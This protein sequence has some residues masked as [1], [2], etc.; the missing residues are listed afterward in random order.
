MQYHENW[1]M[2]ARPLVLSGVF[3]ALLLLLGPPQAAAEPPVEVMILGSYHMANPGQDVHNADVDDVTTDA[4][5]A[6]L[7][8]VSKSLQAFAP[9]KVAIERVSGRD[10]LTVEAYEEFET[11]DLKKTRNES[12][13]IGFRLAHDLGHQAVYGIDEQSDSIDYFPFGKVQEFAKASGDEK[14]LEEFN[15]QAAAFVE[16]INHAQASNPVARALMWV[17]QPS[18][19]ERMQE[20]WYYG[21]LEIGN[22]NE[23]PGALVNGRYYLRNAKIF[24]KLAAVTEPGDRVVVVFGS[25]HS[26]WL[27]HLVSE[28]PGYG[29]IEPND[30]LHTAASH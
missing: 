27:R 26:Y 28:T 8:A 4:K 17:N 22:A 16:G 19:I 14:R 21:L 11:G 7:E 2:R 13:Q 9:T 5:Q 1:H 18:L 20:N 25:G 30:F 3:A 24:S 15:A 10:D 23:Q 29:L 12:V 6:E